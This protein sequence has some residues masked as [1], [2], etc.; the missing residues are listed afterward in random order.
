[1]LLRFIPVSILPL[2]SGQ[3]DLPQHSAY[4]YFIILVYIFDYLLERDS[5]TAPAMHVTHKRPYLC[6]V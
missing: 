2:S 3:N 6:Q 5:E 4:F 1:M